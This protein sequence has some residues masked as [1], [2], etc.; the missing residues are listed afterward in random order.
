MPA[1]INNEQQFREV[2]YFTIETFLSSARIR[3]A[4][5]QRDI[6]G[7]R[8]RTLN[9]VFK[10]THFVQRYD[11]QFRA[12]AFRVANRATSGTRMEHQQ[13]PMRADYQHPNRYCAAA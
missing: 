9:A 10:E 2:P 12:E 5:A 6:R 13:H 3:A 1:G 11:L 8:G 7:P 4:S